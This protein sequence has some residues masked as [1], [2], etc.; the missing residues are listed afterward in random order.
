LLVRKYYPNS[1]QCPVAHVHPHIG[2]FSSQS[3][4]I[5]FWPSIF[6]PSALKWSSLVPTSTTSQ[7][8]PHIQQYHSKCSILQ[9]IGDK[10]ESFMQNLHHQWLI[11]LDILSGDALAQ[12]LN[13]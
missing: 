13:P 6:Q 10:G 1:A 12:N 7:A 11:C 9:W 4:N 5:P 8:I 2:L 3:I